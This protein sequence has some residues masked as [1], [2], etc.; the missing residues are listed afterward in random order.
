MSIVYNII[1]LTFAVQG[2]LSP[3]LA[4]ILMP[5]SS[6]SI[7]LITYGSSNL[8]AKFLRL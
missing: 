2:L 5:A 8:L 4:A 6:L 1:G 7:L 3:L